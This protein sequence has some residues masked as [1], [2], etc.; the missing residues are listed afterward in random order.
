M[1]HL[2]KIFEKATLISATQLK[3]SLTDL[4]PYV[5]ALHLTDPLFSEKVSIKAREIFENSERE[6][7]CYRIIAV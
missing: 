2:K 4:W 1:M 6:R 7:E 3:I 5:G